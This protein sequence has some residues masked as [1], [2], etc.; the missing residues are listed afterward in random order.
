M[1]LYVKFDYDTPRTLSHR[2]RD[3]FASPTPYCD[4]NMLQNTIK[5]LDVKESIAD[6]ESTHLEV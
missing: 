5:R 6:S 4:R 1:M 2:F 3:E